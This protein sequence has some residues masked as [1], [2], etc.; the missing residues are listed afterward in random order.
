LTRIQ[1]LFYCLFGKGEKMNKI[2]DMRDRLNEF[3]VEFDNLMNL[4]YKKIG[5]VKLVKWLSN[6]I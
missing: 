1:V 6:K 5:I 4:V 2:S 3:R